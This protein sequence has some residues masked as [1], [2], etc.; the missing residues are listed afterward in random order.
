MHRVF[1]IVARNEEVAVD[2]RESGVGNN[3][4]VAVLM[5]DETAANFIA[6][7]GFV[8][9]NFFSGNGTSL[10]GRGSRLG[11]LTEEESA[12][13]KLLDETTFL[14][15]LEHVEQGAAVILPEV[16]GVGEIGE[17]HWAISKL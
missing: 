1:N 7:G 5:Q 12:V 8:L 9:G 3:E 17:G 6:R 13:R 16:E 4:A 11:S 14:E 2:V 15:F 10:L